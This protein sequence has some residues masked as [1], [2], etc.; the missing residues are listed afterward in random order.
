MTEE[1]VVQLKQEINRL[2]EEKSDR[3]QALPAHSIRPHQLLVIEELEEEILR[4]ED[5]LKDLLASGGAR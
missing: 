4:K 2:Q 5:E 3:E 1:R